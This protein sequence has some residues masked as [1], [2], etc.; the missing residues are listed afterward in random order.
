MTTERNGTYVPQ[1][2][3]TAERSRFNDPARWE[4][5]TAER[6]VLEAIEV[7]IGQ[8]AEG[9]PTICPPFSSNASSKR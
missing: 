1:R 6:A 8:Q 9:W 2:T 5:S 7:H 4:L 3:R